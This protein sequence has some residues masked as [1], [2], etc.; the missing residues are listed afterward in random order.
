MFGLFNRKAIL[1]YC[2]SCGVDITRL[3]GDVA[4]NGRIYCHGYREGFIRCME[5]D[6]IIN[7]SIFLDGSVMANYKNAKQV[8]RDIRKGTLTHFNQL[9]KVA[10]MN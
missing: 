4:S 9:E 5:K 8:Q 3:G 1:V 2:Q 10:S 7:P 6:L